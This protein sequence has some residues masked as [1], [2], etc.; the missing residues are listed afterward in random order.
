LEGGRRGR[1][2]KRCRGRRKR[3]RGVSIVVVLKRLRWGGWSQWRGSL[4]ESQGQGRLAQ[5]RMF[6]L[7][8]TVERFHWIAWVLI[9]GFSST[10]R[11]RERGIGWDG[12]EGRED[13]GVN[14]IRLRGG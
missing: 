9:H 4:R 7:D 14:V 1:N 2:H 3:G 11:K 8:P 5:G 13:W 12:V 6:R 10:R